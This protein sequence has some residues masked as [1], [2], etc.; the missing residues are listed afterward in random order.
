M[1]PLFAV[2]IFH[3]QLLLL[4]KYLKEFWHAAFQR[5]DWWRDW[6][7]CDI[8]SLPVVITP[9][10]KQFLSWLVCSNNAFL[11]LRSYCSDLMHT[12]CIHKFESMSVCMYIYYI[13][14]IIRSLQYDRNNR[15][16]LWHRL[17]IIR[18]GV[19]IGLHLY[20][21]AKNKEI[22]WR[23]KNSREVSEHPIIV[24]RPL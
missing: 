3:H 8:C 20:Q 10:Q 18:R 13:Y 2:K 14:N 21:S 5:L 11:L 16:A 22:I 19:T 6:R 4:I 24:L 15:N 7:W 1:H 23:R 17:T 12:T 9:Q